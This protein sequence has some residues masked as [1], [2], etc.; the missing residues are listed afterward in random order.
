M[1]KRYIAV[2]FDAAIDAID[3]RTVR[4]CRASAVLTIGRH[5]ERAMPPFHWEAA[6]LPCA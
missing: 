6:R 4:K 2:L 5:D 3:R 1:F